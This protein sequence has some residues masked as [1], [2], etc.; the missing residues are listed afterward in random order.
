MEEISLHTN[1]YSNEKHNNQEAQR[2]RNSSMINPDATIADVLNVLNEIEEKNEELRLRNEHLEKELEEINDLKKLEELI[3]QVSIENDELKKE[4]EELEITLASKNIEIEKLYD[5]IKALTDSNNHRNSLNCVDVF[6][7][8][9][10]NLK[11]K[12]FNKDEE[13]KHLKSEIIFANDAIKILT[14]EKSELKETQLRTNNTMKNEKQAHLQTIED[15]KMDIAVKDEKIDQLEDQIEEMKS[16]HS[17][18]IRK[19]DIL[20]ENSNQE[21]LKLK[22]DI[23]IIKSQQ[24]TP[25][26]K[27]VTSNRF[28]LSAHSAFAFERP[29][30]L[31]T[32]STRNDSRMNNLETLLTENF[33]EEE[34]NELR[35]DEDI[36]LELNQK[37]I[38]FLRITIEDFFTIGRGY[39]SNNRENNSMI[40]TDNFEILHL[41]DPNSKYSLAENEDKIKTLEESLLNLNV[42]YNNLLLEFQH[43]Q[44]IN[45]VKKK[46]CRS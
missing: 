13:I 25:T 31:N 12:L 7:I 19:K 21:I 46:N 42:N 11:S 40:S 35:S 29:K 2:K 15:L 18:N 5:E 10:D 4:K 39:C 38:Q 37:E 27:K 3:T 26:N 23:E 1:V 22:K 34:Y 8:Q 17:N 30:Q 33:E 28:R 14:K 41:L 45:K 32:N 36:N 9:I 43:L 44:C 24:V 16:N 20:I 6:E